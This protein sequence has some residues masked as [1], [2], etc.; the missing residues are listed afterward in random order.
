MTAQ[1]TPPPWRSHPYSSVVGCPITAQPDP[2]K[3]TINITAT[4]G[5][6]EQAEPNAA[7]IVHACNAHEELVAVLEMFADENAWMEWDDR[8]GAFL[9]ASFKGDGKPWLIARA[10]LAKARDTTEA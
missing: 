8:K 3:D 10:A 2:T 9:K 6:Q 1:H 4:I 5:E 7:F